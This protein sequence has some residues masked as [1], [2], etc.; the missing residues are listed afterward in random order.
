MDTARE[1]SHAGVAPT[2]VNVG[3]YVNK[4]G[5]KGKNLKE[6]DLDVDDSKNASFNSDIGDENDP[7]R[8][9]EQKF[10]KE[11]AEV[12]EDFA[13]KERTAG[14]GKTQYDVLEETNA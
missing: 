1:P 11:N 2:Y 5:P 4:G 14:G 6:E 9:A 13:P 12:A 10:A 3:Q 8:L 7:G